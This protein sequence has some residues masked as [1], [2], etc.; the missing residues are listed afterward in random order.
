MIV[1]WLIA[2]IGIVSIIFLTKMY[3]DKLIGETESS[4]EVFEEYKEKFEEKLG[5]TEEELSSKDDNKTTYL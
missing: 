4:K 2:I 5:M 1:L 3:I